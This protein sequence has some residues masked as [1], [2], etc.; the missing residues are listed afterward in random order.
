MWIR[1]RPAAG[2]WSKVSMIGSPSARSGAISSSPAALLPMQV[3]SIVSSGL[4]RIGSGTSGI[5]GGRRKRTIEVTSSGTS[6]A[7]SR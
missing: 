3:A 1:L 6:S 2:I 7:Q 5:G 4:S